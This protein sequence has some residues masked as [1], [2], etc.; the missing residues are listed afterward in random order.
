[1]I[2]RWSS[3]RFSRLGVDCS[4]EMITQFSE[5]GVLLLMFIADLETDVESL[6]QNRNSSIAF[7]VGGLWRLFSAIGWL[8]IGME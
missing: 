2:I 7:A 6:K 3:Y 8:V 5:I 4:V 1:M